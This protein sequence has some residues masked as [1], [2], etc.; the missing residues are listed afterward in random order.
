MQLC[1]FRAPLSR[2]FAVKVTHRASAVFKIT[3][4]AQVYGH[5]SVN[6][7][8]QMLAAA[9]QVQDANCQQMQSGRNISA[10]K[11]VHQQAGAVKRISVK[12][13]LCRSDLRAGVCG[14]IH[15]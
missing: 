12:F 14:G 10:W 5:A 8:R 4:L 3:I 2:D 11:D 13:D 15:R 9:R 6:A 7:C 1:G